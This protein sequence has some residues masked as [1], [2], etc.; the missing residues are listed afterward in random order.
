MKKLCIQTQLHGDKIYLRYIEN[1]IQLRKLVVVKVAILIYNGK[2]IQG[3]CLPE[4][5]SV[6][7]NDSNENL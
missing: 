5:S 2:K 6:N 3:Y 4:I 7:S 1:F